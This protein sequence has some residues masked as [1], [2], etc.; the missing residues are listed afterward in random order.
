MVYVDAIDEGKIIRVTREHAIREGLMILR[1]IED[2]KQHIEEVKRKGREEGKMLFDDFRKPL[3]WQK[4]QV[5]AELMDNFHWEIVRA[6]KGRNLTRKQVATALNVREEDIKS[7]ENGLVP[8]PDFVLINKL[9]AYLGINI[10]KD[11]QDYSNEA[12]KLIP[13]RKW[14]EKTVEKKEEP[15][16]ESAMAKKEELEMEDSNTNDEK[17][18]DDS[19]SEEIDVELADD[20]EE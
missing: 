12:R 3:S 7:L 13:A 2:K 17:K 8:N 6:R 4:N 16:R 10:R 20:E 5:Y 19:N 1:E 15:R 9:Q 14:N 18:V 11:R